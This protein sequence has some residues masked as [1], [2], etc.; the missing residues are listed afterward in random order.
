LGHG[1]YLAGLPS[2]APLAGTSLTPPPNSA[3]TSPATP[4]ECNN[5][6]PIVAPC[7][8]VTRGVEIPT[9]FVG[10]TE[11]RQW[12]ESH[13]TAVKEAPPH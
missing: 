8:R 4:T 11:R 3:T 2:G 7:H 10:G 12:L 13:E 1:R 6:I 5:P 9:T